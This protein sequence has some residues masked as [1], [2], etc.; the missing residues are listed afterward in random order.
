MND[1]APLL[2]RALVGPRGSGKS[3]A[4]ERLIAARPRSII[5]D[6]SGSMD[7]ADYISEDAEEVS[8]WVERRPEGTWWRAIW[9][10]AR[11][12]D[13]SAGLARLAAVAEAVPGDV[14]LAVDELGVVRQ[15]ARA[16]IDELEETAR[17]GR[18]RGVS[19][20][21]A[22]QRLRDVPVDLLS[23]ID[24]VWIYG[25]S[26]PRDQEIVRRELDAEGGMLDAIRALPQYECVEWSTT[27]SRWAPRGRLGSDER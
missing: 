27:T 6:P 13:Y 8:A 16:A 23:V 14:T 17:L 21:V 4:L 10:P 26:G 15:R 5:I 19:V 18:H 22:S 1:A 3:Y 25:V 12:S 2:N 7:D 11:R 9:H 20:W 24:V